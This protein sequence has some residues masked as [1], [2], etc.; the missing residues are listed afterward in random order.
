MSIETYD[1]QEIEFRWRSPNSVLG[2]DVNQ[3]YLRK[4]RLLNEPDMIIWRRDEDWSPF[5]MYYKTPATDAWN[6][7]TRWLKGLT[8]QRRAHNRVQ[9]A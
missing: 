8:Q 2:K 7:F 5:A 1:M 4:L 6:G 3:R 9:A